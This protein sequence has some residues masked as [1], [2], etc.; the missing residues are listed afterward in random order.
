[1]MHTVSIWMMRLVEAMFFTGLTGC[2][3]VVV[4]SWISIFSSG[5][6]RGE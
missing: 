5:F 3:V 6:K 1:M 4:V 2:A